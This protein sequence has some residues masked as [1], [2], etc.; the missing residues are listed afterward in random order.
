MV[1]GMREAKFDLWMRVSIS[2]ADLIGVMTHHTGCFA[3]FLC[4]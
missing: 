2:E 4:C 1:L 3:S